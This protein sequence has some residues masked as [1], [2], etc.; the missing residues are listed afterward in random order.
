MVF[1]QGEAAVFH[2]PLLA[3]NYIRLSAPGQIC[4]EEAPVSKIICPFHLAP[5][6]SRHALSFRAKRVNFKDKLA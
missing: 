5:G 3:L 6:K 1:Y 2:L 4:P